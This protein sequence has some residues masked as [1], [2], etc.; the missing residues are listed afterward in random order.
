MGVNGGGL[1]WRMAGLLGL[2]TGIRCISVP[3]PRSFSLVG[4]F[5]LFPAFPCI[6]RAVPWKRYLY[7]GET[8][9]SLTRELTRDAHLIW[10][11]SHSATLPQRKTTHI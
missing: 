1:P 4:C 6:D 7:Q 11:I 3:C 10:T 2:G 5:G 8:L 9:G